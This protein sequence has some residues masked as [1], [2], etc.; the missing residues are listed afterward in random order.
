MTNSS[1][2]TSH[3]WEPRRIAELSDR[4]IA[5]LNYEEM[6]QLVVSARGT[7]WEPPRLQE[8]DSDV[9][10]RLVYAARAACRRW[11]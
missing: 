1:V 4:E 3:D 9:L 11:A 6:I 10:M 8:I 2:A 5:G 7:D